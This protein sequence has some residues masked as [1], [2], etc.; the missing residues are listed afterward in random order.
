LYSNSRNGGN[1]SI[2]YFN[3]ENKSSKDLKQY[4]GNLIEQTDLPH[5]IILDNLHNIA[6]ISDAFSEF[7]TCKNSKKLEY[8]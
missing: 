6:N 2:E 7:F 3:V 4:L 5:V 1:N 8:V